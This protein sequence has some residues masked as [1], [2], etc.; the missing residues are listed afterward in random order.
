MSLKN[1]SP[2]SRPRNDAYVAR[3]VTL[4]SVKCLFIK[5]KD[6]LDTLPTIK[7]YIAKI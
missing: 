3:K 4:D 1:S 6:K 5:P 7:K 2:K